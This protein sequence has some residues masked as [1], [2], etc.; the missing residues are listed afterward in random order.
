M[1]TQETL[2]PTPL[3]DKPNADSR[4]E[5]IQDQRLGVLLGKQQAGELTSD[6]QP[7]TPCINASLSRR[8]AA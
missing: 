2:S 5:P 3:M 7:R 1:I 8:A 6:E 4:M